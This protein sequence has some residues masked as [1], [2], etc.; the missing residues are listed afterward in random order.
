[1]LTPEEKEEIKKLLMRGIP[2]FRIAIDLFHSPKTIR[3]VRSKMHDEL[4]QSPKSP[5]VE[6][7]KSFTI[8]PLEV[9][10]LGE[11]LVEGKLDPGLEVFVPV[12]MEIAHKYYEILKLSEELEPI[13]EGISE[14]VREGIEKERSE[15]DDAG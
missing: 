12:P 11:L 7:P 3:K 8:I 9:G 1:M 13:L 5:I 10:F 14:A 15:L 4:S 6:K 2:V